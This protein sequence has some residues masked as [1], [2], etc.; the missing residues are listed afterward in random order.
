MELDE[1]DLEK[2]NQP[3]TFQCKIHKKESNFKIEPALGSFILKNVCV[4]LA[5]K[6]T[7]SKDEVQKLII[8]AWIA[9]YQNPKNIDF[10][11]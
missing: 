3:W 6:G 8:G 11:K 10:S 9:T 1:F 2:F 7:I 5:Q 4:Q